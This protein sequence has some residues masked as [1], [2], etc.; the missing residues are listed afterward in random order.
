MAPFTVMPRE[1][2]GHSKVEVKN[3]KGKNERLITSVQIRVS[4][5]KITLLAAD[6]E[7]SPPVKR[8]AKSDYRGY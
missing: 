4:N 6:R 3:N 2:K 1:I 7:S 8:Q 5:P